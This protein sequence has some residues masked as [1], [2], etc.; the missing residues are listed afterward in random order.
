M[1]R[2]AAFI[3][4]ANLAHREAEVRAFVAQGAHDLH[5]IMSPPPAS[6]VRRSQAREMDPAA[7]AHQVTGIMWYLTA[8]AV[9]RNQSFQDGAFVCRD[10][11]GRLSDYFQSIGTP[12]ISSHLKRHSAPGCT[13][14]VD[15]F[16]NDNDGGIPPLAH[17]HRHVLY[18][19][20][21]QGK[22]RDSCLFLK[23]EHYGV[24]SFQ[25]WVNH[26]VRYG[27]SLVRRYLCF[28]GMD[29]VGMRKER[30]PDHVVRAFSQAVARLPDGSSAI[31]VVG[32]H[33]EGEGIGY[34]HE[35]LTAKLADPT[36][37]ESARM[38]LLILLLRLRS[39]YDFVSLRF[40]NE[41]FLD[42]PALLS[43]PLPRA[44]EVK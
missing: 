40:G 42:L 33:G 21:A 18:I 34:M 44:A 14:G 22:R 41:V 30:I 3:A 15:L 12:R 23:P 5:T 25:D 17:G 19:A 39:Q 20:I 10:P 37:S 4:V 2:L 28:H 35:Y 27:R 7:R 13:G 24:A 29:D 43:G 1:D 8:L 32:S 31:A 38:P 26:A 36:L 9:A 11:H 6:E 16:T